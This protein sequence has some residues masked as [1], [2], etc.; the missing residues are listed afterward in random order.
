MIIK[1]FQLFGFVQGVHV[2]LGTMKNG[3]CDF[4]IVSCILGWH[5]N[6]GEKPHTKTMY[7]VNYP[8]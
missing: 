3:Y 4:V 5:K 1:N 7:V 6:E 2:G 8:S